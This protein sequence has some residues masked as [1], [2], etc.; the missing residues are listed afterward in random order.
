VEEEGRVIAGEGDLVRVE[1]ERKS[2]CATCRACSLGRANTVVTEAKNPL[3]ARIGQRVKVEISSP[4]ILKGAFFVY[5]FPLFGLI[6]GMGLGLAI[7]NRL[8]FGEDSQRIGIIVGLISLALSF[9]FIWRR[10]RRMKARGAY[11][12]RIIR[13]MEEKK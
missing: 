9:L 13:I 4:A 1:M 10:S 11:L 7:G 2:A 6:F 12:S 5:I 3:G 8:G